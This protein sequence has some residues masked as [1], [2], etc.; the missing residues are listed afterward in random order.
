MKLAILK[1]EEWLA[2]ERQN[3]SEY[4][5]GRDILRR[6]L[7]IAQAKYEMTKSTVQTLEAILVV[8]R[9]AVDS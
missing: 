5:E 8:A 6:D 9:N 4:Q 7:E 3:A 1:L 2:I